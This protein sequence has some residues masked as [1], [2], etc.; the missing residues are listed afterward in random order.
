MRNK[1]PCTIFFSPTVFFFIIEKYFMLH[2]TCS[3][4]EIWALAVT[5]VCH[6]VSVIVSLSAHLYNSAVTG[7]RP[8]DKHITP[9]SLH[10]KS[11]RSNWGYSDS[12]YPSRAPASSSR[13]W[14]HLTPWPLGDEER[15]LGLNY[16]LGW[17]RRGTDETN[18]CVINTK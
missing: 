14:V 18:C 8:V 9:Y 1:L 13:L 12:L 16:S 3:N 2:L 4:S 11:Y 7:E 6:A 10:L 15:F 17:D 5:L